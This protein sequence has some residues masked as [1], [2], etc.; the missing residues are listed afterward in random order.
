MW[1]DEGIQDSSGGKGTVTHTL[2]HSH[3]QVIEIGMQEE[4]LEMR[5]ANIMEHN[6]RVIAR[7]EEESDWIRQGEHPDLTGRGVDYPIMCPDCDQGNCSNDII[8]IAIVTTDRY[9]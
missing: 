5:T 1:C 7:V 9:N 4:Y 3:S 8:H 2:S 6:R